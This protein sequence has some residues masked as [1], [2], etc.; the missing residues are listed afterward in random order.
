MGGARGV[1]I[2]ASRQVNTISRTIGPRLGTDSE[3]GRSRGKATKESS[4]DVPASTIL[5]HGWQR[6]GHEVDKGALLLRHVAAF[7][8]HD[9][10]PT[11]FSSNSSS[12]GTS[13]PASTSS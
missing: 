9:I 6:L 13:R 4:M 1:P 5:H 2:S 10:D 8:V 12:T 3:L 11:P 7:G